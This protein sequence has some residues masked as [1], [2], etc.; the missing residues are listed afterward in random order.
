MNLNHSSDPTL[1]TETAENPNEF[2]K[3]YQSSDYPLTGQG[4]VSGH[5]LTNSG[6]TGIVNVQG[7]CIESSN[8]SNSLHKDSTQIIQTTNTGIR[9]KYAINVELDEEEIVEVGEDRTTQ[10]DIS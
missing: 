3:D 8:P 6:L 7:N 10:P 2:G 4:Q 9:S 5:H 1:L